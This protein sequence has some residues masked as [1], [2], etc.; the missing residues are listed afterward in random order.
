M[1]YLNPK[2]VFKDHSKICHLEL[3]L[4]YLVQSVD[5]LISPMDNF[6]GLWKTFINE[7]SCDIYWMWNSIYHHICKSIFWI[8]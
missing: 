8:I 2:T 4:R 1:A 3:N 7:L 6:R 5:K